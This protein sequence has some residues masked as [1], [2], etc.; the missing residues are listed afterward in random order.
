[1]RSRLLALTIALVGAAA[2]SGGESGCVTLVSSPCTGPIDTTG[3]GGGGGGGGG[4]TVTTG[5]VDKTIVVD[6]TTYAYKVFVPANYNE[7]TTSKLA[8]ILFMHGSGEKGSDNVTQLANGLGPIVKANVSTFPEIV[9][10]PQGPAG[11]GT[12]QT[13]VKIAKA[14]L[15]A[16]MNG[17]PKADAR[18]VYLTGLSYGGIH[19]FEL[20]YQNPTTFAAIVPISATVCAACLTPGWSFAQGVQA[21]TQV[22]KPIPIWQFQGEL[23]TQ[24]KLTD[25]RAIESSFLSAA[26]P[27]K[28]TVYA[29]GQHDIWDRAYGD[30]SMWTW[31]RAKSR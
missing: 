21:V 29:G 25:A 10:F 13:F 5:L 15:D 6:G 1:M 2:C 4:A 8:V 22:L 3:G 7:S 12:Y 17:Y 31:L 9:V 18:R 20:A 11:E 23:D 26:A 24:V 19:L 16:T 27:Y 28:L 14:S 30:A